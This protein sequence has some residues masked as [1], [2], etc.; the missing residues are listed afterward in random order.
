MTNRHAISLKVNGT[1]YSCDV[2]A[3]MSLADCLREQLDLTGTHLGCEH[4]VCGACTV[5]ADGAAI[6]SCLI[7]AVQAHKMDIT[8][9]EGLA[10]GEN[11]SPLQ[12]AF[13]D[14]HALQCGFCTPGMLTTAEA[15]LGENPTPTRAEVESAISGNICRCTGYVSIVDAIMDAA[16]RRSGGVSI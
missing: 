3:R 10:E 11:L 13:R 6:R 16:A 15:F 1:S 5:I 14:N 12:E 8:T 2:D 7:F 4:G 9:V